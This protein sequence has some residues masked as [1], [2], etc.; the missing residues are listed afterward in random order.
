MIGELWH[1]IRNWIQKQ[2]I[3]VMQRPKAHIRANVCVPSLKLRPQMKATLG[4]VTISVEKPSYFSVLV[5]QRNPSSFFAKWLSIWRY[6]DIY[7]RAQHG[8]DFA[9]YS[10]ASAA[11]CL[12][13]LLTKHIPI[14]KRVISF[15]PSV[16]MIG[17]SA[18]Q[19]SWKEISSYHMSSVE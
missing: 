4:P 7:W 11:E 16:P 18:F 5:F 15:V 9:V 8:F 2:W 14:T 13:V 17:Q 12:L 6:T 1:G 3:Q 19:S 10:L